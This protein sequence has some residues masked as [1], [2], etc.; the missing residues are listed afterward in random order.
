M[1]THFGT[2]YK[3]LVKIEK[4]VKLDAV[5]KP[6]EVTQTINSN[7][8][9]PKPD[10]YFT[11]KEIANELGVANSLLYSFVCR[12]SNFIDRVMKVG[13]KRRKYR[14]FYYVLFTRDKSR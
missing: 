12:A 6:V 14:V 7:K 13:V 4:N 9:P 10:G 5:E 11:T 2:K 1:M 3:N 8:L